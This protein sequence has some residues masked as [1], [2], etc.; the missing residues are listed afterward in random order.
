MMRVI[1]FP[2]LNQYFSG[3]IPKPMK[4]VIPIDLSEKDAQVIQFMSEQF[5]EPVELYLFHMM[6]YPILPGTFT[7]LS[8]AMA[9]VYAQMRKQADSGIKLLESNL[10][11]R[12]LKVS[13]SHIE[14]AGMPLGTAIHTFAQ[15]VHADLILLISRHRK[16]LDAIFEGSNL[17]SI[18]R[19]CTTPMLILSPAKLSPIHRLGFATD[20]S[21]ESGKALAKVQAFAR[22]LKI[23]LVCYRVNT[24]DNFCDQRA[25]VQDRNEFLNANGVGEIPEIQSY[26]AWDLEE[27]IRNAAEDFLADTIAL[28]TH[29]RKGLSRL[30]NGSVTEQIIR[31]TTAPVWVMHQSE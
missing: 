26:N 11:G 20:F 10:E 9:E 4:I 21:K 30:F 31:S 5:K 27:G 14:E 25:F 18:I 3:K 19:S 23:G 8:G 6:H 13:G 15:Q 24:P 2:F 7:D 1:G 16:G 29:A 22:S 17:L 12:G 28:T